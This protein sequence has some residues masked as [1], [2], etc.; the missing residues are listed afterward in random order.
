MTSYVTPARV[1]GIDGRTVIDV[2][3]AFRYDQ[4]KPFEFEVIFSATR[5]NDEVRWVVSLDTLREGVDAP[6]GLADFQVWPEGEKLAF[7]LE[8]EE[9]S[10]VTRLDLSS[11]KSFLQIIS[12]E[13]EMAV[14]STDDK[15]ELAIDDFLI[16]LGLT[17]ANLS[18]GVPNPGGPSQ[19]QGFCNICGRVH[20]GNGCGD[21]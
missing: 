3:L 21:Y 15:V 10:S 13:E 4:D 14:L 11:V 16:E 1:T 2:D 8:S 9:G 6:S 12:E 18:F 19:P 5:Y 17:P 20:S 7:R